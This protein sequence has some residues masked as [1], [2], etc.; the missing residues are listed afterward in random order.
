MCIRA[1]GVQ[2]VMPA[3]TT[4]ALSGCSA[5]STSPRCQQMPCAQVGP[6]RTLSMASRCSGFAAAQPLTARRPC[7]AASTYRRHQAAVSCIATTGD[8]GGGSKTPLGGGGEVGAIAQLLR[9]AWGWL[10]GLQPPKSMW[11]SIAALVLGGEALVRILQGTLCLLPR[12]WH[13]Q[14]LLL[15]DRCRSLLC[16]AFLNFCGHGL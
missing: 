8:S 14:P 11:R 15:R 10:N 5:A 1:A 7:P 16:R 9:G 6:R 3:Q 4:A 2:N 12:A 13:L